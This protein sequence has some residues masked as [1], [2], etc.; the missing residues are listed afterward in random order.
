MGET[1][2]GTLDWNIREARPADWPAVAEFNRLLALETEAKALDIQFVEPG[3][4]RLI[5]N[6]SLG[7]YFLAEA[8]DRV[9]GQ[10]AITFEWSDWR[11]GMLWWLQSVY[12]ASGWRGR[13][14]F[15]SLY[16]YVENLGRRDPDVCGIRLYVDER[17]TPAHGVYEALGFTRTGYLVLEKSLRR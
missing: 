12:V 11:N 7:R 8:S 4:R 9:I 5:G 13:G 10:L 16:Q 2:A 3:V 1:I 6:P 17:N 15:R 14:V